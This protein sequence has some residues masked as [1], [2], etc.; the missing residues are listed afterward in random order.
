MGKIIFD[1]TPE[2]ARD[3]ERFEDNTLKPLKARELRELFEI[4]AG[5]THSMSEK[6]L[7]DLHQR[8]LRDKKLIAD[9]KKALDKIKEIEKNG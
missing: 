9:L 6:E 5:A 2:D 1:P 8:E 7:E 3:T 4:I